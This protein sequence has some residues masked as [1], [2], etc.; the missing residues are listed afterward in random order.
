MDIVIVPV[1]K[2][3]KKDIEPLIAGMG[4]IFRRQ[5]IIGEEMPE[6]DF[7]FNKK[8]DQYSAELILNALIENKA[9]SMYKRT[10]GVVDHDLY[11][12]DMSFIFGLAGEKAAIISIARLRQQF[13]GLSENTDRFNQRTLTEAVHELGHTYGL[14]HCNNSRCVMYFSYSLI[15]TD[16]KG[17]EFCTRCRYRLSVV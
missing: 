4:N 3:D 16:R 15:D 9:Y 10:L 2:I 1:G 6:P 17:A 14:G 8:R 11:A 13:Y 5:V 12:P 7:A